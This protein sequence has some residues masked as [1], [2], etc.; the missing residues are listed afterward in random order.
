MDFLKVLL[1]DDNKTVDE[2]LQIVEERLRLK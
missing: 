2:T 1:R